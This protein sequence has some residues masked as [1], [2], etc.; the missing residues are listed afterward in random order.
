MIEEFS[1]KAESSGYE[2]YGQKVNIVA[3]TQK[4]DI[5]IVK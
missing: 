2:G 4:V 3:D 1:A 5:E